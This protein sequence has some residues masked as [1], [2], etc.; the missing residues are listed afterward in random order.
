M[1]CCAQG[2]RRSC[3]D[4]NRLGLGGWEQLLDD[5]AVCVG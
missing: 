2:N 1:G 4:V 3:S 5:E